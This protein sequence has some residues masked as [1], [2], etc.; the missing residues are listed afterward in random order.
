MQEL[1]HICSIEFHRI[2]ILELDIDGGDEGTI[3]QMYL[4]PLD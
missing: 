3:K 1:F 2:R 4:M